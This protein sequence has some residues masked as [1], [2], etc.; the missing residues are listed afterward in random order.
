[1]KLRT[2]LPTREGD[3]VV[4][5]ANFQEQITALGAQIGLLPAQISAYTTLHEAFL[6]YYDLCQRNNTRTPE[7]L[8]HKKVAK[9]ALIRGENGIRQ[10]VG[11]IQKH[12]GTTNPMRVLL[13]I[14]VPDVEPSVI[15]PPS[16][17]PELTIVSTL[18]RRVT[19]RLRDSKDPD[20]RSKPSGVSGAS[21][22][23][24]VGENPPAN[25]LEWAFLMNTSR[26]SLEIDFPS[27]IPG[28]SKVWL[29]AFWFNPR[30]Q[31]GPASAAVNTLI[32]DG[33]AVK[34]AA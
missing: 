23:M 10:L 2:F 14:T 29:V 21:I 3:L 19:L 17:A 20:K 22:V 12:P 24:H 11:I 6:S 33:V 4:W 26:T 9:Q 5:S 27:T 32:S 25:P 34:L 16:T 8:E 30:K 18:R 7:N 15:P 1:M 28:G 31:A 13:K